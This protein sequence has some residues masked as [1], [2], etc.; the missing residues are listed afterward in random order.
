MHYKYQTQG[1][2]SMQIEFDMEG[3]IATKAVR[4]AYKS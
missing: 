1:I 4:Q 3:N 2:C